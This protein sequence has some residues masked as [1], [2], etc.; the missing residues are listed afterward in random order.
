MNFPNF[1]LG[2]DH[3]REPTPTGT[4]SGQTQVLQNEEREIDVKE[5]QIIEEYFMEGCGCLRRCSSHIDESFLSKMR[6]NCA[7]LTH[8][9]LDLL[10]MGQ[11]LAVV[12]YSAATTSMRHEPHHSIKK[13]TQFLFGG[14]NVKKG[15]M[16]EHSLLYLQL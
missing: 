6:S 15:S 8:D 3:D 4:S 11:L 1:H 12:N 16:Y 13:S 7:E 9:Q 2:T 10:V 14:D 5:R